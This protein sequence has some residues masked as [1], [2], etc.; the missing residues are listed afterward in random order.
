[1]GRLPEQWSLDLDWGRTPWQGRTPRSLTKVALAACG[2][3]PYVVEAREGS[4]D[5][6]DPAQYLLFLKGRS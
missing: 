3:L 4:E 1:M 6:T 5:F 2:K